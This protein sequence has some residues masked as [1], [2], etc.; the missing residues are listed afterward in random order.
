MKHAHHHEPAEFQKLQIGI[1]VVSDTRTLETDTSGQYLT[2]VL[3]TTGHQVK[4]R[5]IVKDEVAAIQE[6]LIA[7]SSDG[8]FQAV[9]VTGGTGV[10]ARDVTPEAVEPLYTKTLP[11]FGELFRM[12]SY[13][14]IS[15]ACIQSRASAGLI[16][17]MLVF[18]LPGSRGACR[19][20]LEDIILPQ[21]DASTLPC[22]FPALFSRM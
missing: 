14:E 12:L 16:G 21:L 4:D 13:Q 17:K 6:K 7:W 18:C 22:S 9:L 11:G 20:A 5:S 15:T 8:D 3:E 2:A 1:L 19:L 10:T